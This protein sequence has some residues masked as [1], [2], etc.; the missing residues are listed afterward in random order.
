MARNRKNIQKEIKNLERKMNLLELSKL[1][2]EEELKP[3]APES[4]L[5][6]LKQDKEFIIFALKNNIRGIK[7]KLIYISEVITTIE[8]NVVDLT[9]IQKKIETTEGI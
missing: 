6:L 1:K 7:I 3:I 8:N 5:N 4:M 2:L 9:I